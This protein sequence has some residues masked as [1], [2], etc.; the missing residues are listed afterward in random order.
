MQFPHHI[1]SL[2]SAT[3]SLSSTNSLLRGNYVPVLQARGATLPQR[4]EKHGEVEGQLS[5]KFLL[6][7]VVYEDEPDFVYVIQRFA[8]Y[9]PEMAQLSLPDVEPRQQ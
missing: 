4:T 2:S 7:C 3:I 9:R 5:T 1:C 8:R 6:E